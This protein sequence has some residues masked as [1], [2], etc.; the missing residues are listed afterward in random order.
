MYSK[1]LKKK[2]QI[3]EFRRP[4]DLAL[5]R[6]ADRRKTGLSPDTSAGAMDGKARDRMRRALQC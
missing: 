2:I 1:I 6:W 4:F 5:W 3:V